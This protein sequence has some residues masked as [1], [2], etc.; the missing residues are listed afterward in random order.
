MRSL[1]AIVASPRRSQMLDRLEWA[2]YRG[3]N[4]PAVGSPS[5]RRDPGSSLKDR[6]LAINLEGCGQ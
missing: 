3:E 1:A 4:M 5:L 2:G 6:R